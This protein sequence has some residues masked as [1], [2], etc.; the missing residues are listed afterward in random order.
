MAGRRVLITGAYGLIGHESVIA[1]RAAGFDVVPTDILP[2]RPADAHFDAVPLAVSGVDPLARFLNEHGIGAIVHAAGISG[3]M[4]AKDAPHA[5]L[6]TNVGGAI[7]LYEAARLASISKV[8][9]ISS[10]GAYGETGDATVEEST[11]LRA[12]GTYGV[13]K[14]CTEKVAQAYA[15]FGVDTVALRPS[16]VYGPRRRTTC[17]IKTMV[18]RALSSQATY[19]TY[20]AGFPRQFVHVTDVADSV[21]AALTASPGGWS[22]YNITDGHRYMLDE[23]AQLVRDR[24][25]LAKIDLA[26]G[27]DPDDFICGPMDISAAWAHLGWQ[28]KIDLPSGIDQMIADLSGRL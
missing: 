18:D 28:P 21:V 10:A 5:L 16:W 9:L 27:P 12:T 3:P 17:V 2:E 4:L 7:D 13:S 19:F 15:G 11:P 22:A 14:I 1:L 8:V 25:P 26:T 20:G 23:V 6:S 24:M